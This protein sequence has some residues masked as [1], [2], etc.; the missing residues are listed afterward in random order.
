MI[1]ILMKL[2]NLTHFI[3]S[4]NLTHF[5]VSILPEPPTG[6]HH[7]IGEGDERVAVGIGGHERRHLSTKDLPGCVEVAGKLTVVR[8]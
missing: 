1:K 8:I 7:R 3:V 5:T 6:D 2:S 4:I